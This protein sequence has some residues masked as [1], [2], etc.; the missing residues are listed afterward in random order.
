MGNRLALIVHGLR[1]LAFLFGVLATSAGMAHADGLQALQDFLQHNRSGRADF[2]QKVTA[3]P[4][5]GQTPRIKTSRGSLAYQ[6]PDLFR[7]DYTAPDEQTLLADGR[8]FWHLDADLRQVTVRPQKSTLAQAPAALIL[9]ASDLSMLKSTFDLRALP[10]ADGLFW[11]EVTPRSSDGTLRQ[12]RVG[13]RGLG[14]QA[15]VAR[16][17]FTDGFGQSS[18]LELSGFVGGAPPASTFVLKPP[19]GFQVLR[20]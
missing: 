13:L 6:R 19:A 9:T 10:D 16:L 18:R 8:Q 17:E 5:E 2:V 1:G 3:P 20:P 15:Q 11:V 7:L 14:A 12:L 4:R